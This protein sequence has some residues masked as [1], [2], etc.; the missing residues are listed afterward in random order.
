MIPPPRVRALVWLVFV[1]GMLVARIAEA[2]QAGESGTVLTL[3]AA[4]RIALQNN[5]NVKVAAAEVEKA[6]Q[7][8]QAAKTRRL[9]TFN[10]SFVDPLVFT[11]LDLR[12]GPLGRLGLPHNFSF[13]SG[14]AAQP[15]S[16]LYDIGLGVKASALSRDLASERLRD[17]RQTMVNEIKRAYYGCLRAES[18]LKP[19][20]EAVELF[21]EL[22]RVVTSLVDERAALES[23]RLD[24]EVRRAQQE[25]DVMV[26]ENA[27]I[28]GRERL[29]AALA[30][31]IDTPFDLEAVPATVPA[32]AD[33]AAART[34]AIDERPDVR[35]ARLTV[36]LARTDLKLKKAD[37]MPHV[38]ALF[39][40][41]GTINMPLLPGHNAAVLLQVNWEPFSWGRKSK[42]LIVKQLAVEQAET[43]VRE[44]EATIAVDLN[45]KFRALLEA[46]SLITV[47]ELGERA[48]GERL[49]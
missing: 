14:T 1:S 31:A 17:A 6:A 25:H 13:A 7:Q 28:T 35:H 22:E 38:N 46:R 15:L 2:A 32:Q 21:R 37:R 40:Y 10:V 3:D 5:R 8:V 19:A 18:G 42:E 48:A 29:N 9:P 24:V 33:L 47:T 16:Q 45:A 41:V 34:R 49:R 36:D 4:V 23:D 27:L 20:R 26:L 12:F 39:A 11:D 30:R 44:L 43:A